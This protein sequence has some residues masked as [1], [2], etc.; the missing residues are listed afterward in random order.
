MSS[1][2][3]IRSRYLALALDARKVIDVLIT[4]VDEGKRGP[5]LEECLQEVIGSLQTVVEKKDIFSPLSN[6]VAFSEY[7]EQVQTVEEALKPAQR[8]EVV[9]KLLAIR[10]N[11]V[12]LAS[13]QE[14]AYQAIKLLSAIES[15]ALHYSTPQP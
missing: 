10:N 11:R 4:F 7:Y 12:D 14:D 1:E 13:Q 2:A 8:E 9:R 15:R 6:R 3:D 5:D